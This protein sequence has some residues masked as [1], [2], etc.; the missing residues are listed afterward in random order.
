MLNDKMPLAAL[1][2]IWHHTDLSMFFFIADEDWTCAVFDF[3]AGPRPE[4][5]NF[6]VGPATSK[7][8]QPLRLKSAFAVHSSA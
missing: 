7:T 2:S 5:D 1:I 4:A 6:A 3:N 8:C